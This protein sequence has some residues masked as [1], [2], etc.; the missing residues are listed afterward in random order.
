MTVHTAIDTPYLSGAFAYMVCVFFLL[1]VRKSLSFPPAMQN[2]FCA[3]VGASYL[4]NLYWLSLIVK[5]V[6]VKK[7]KKKDPAAHLNGNGSTQDMHAVSDRQI[8][9]STQS[10]KVA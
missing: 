6:V 7:K 10:K 2:A 4:L 5:T 9:S 3:A 1:Q 8:D